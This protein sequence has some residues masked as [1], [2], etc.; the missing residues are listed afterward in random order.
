[1]TAPLSSPMFLGLPDFFAPGAAAAFVLTAL[2]VGGLLLVAPAWSAKTVPMRLR[3][4]LLVIFAVLL[5]PSAL[6]SANRTQL[7]ITPAT[8][9]TETAI[10]FALGFAAAI[11]VAGAEFAGEL[12]TTTIGLSG[13]AIFDPVNNTQGA[14]LGSFMQLMAITLLLIAGGHVLMLKAVSQSFISLPLGAPLAMDQGFYA[15]VNAG[16]TI[17][18]TGVQFASP[19][20]AAILVTNLSLAII[21][22]AAPQL[23][24][25]SIAF[26]LQIGIGLLTFAGSIGLVVHAMGDWTTQYGNTMDSFAR[27]AQSAPAPAGRR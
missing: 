18:A 13:A 19:V 5:L 4:A 17:F 26:P 15:L 14:L 12:A 11:I 1:M 22:R 24:I 7:V 6:E 16:R 21:G 9:L 10:G 3:T 8:F 2:R 23:Q 25:M 27:A 20:V